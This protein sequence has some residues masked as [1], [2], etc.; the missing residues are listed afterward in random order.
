MNNITPGTLCLVIGGKVPTNLG[1]TVM[2]ERFVN[3]GSHAITGIAVKDVW[4]VKGE[5]LVF[6]RKVSSHWPWVETEPGNA[7]IFEPHHL[8]PIPPLADPIT[9]KQ[10]EEKPCTA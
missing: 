9:T 3:K 2:T 5:G 8:L 4:V 7:G 1:K 6:R 10:E